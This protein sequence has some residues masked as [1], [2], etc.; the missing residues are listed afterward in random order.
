MAVRQVRLIFTTYSAF[1]PTHLALTSCYGNSA[2]LLRSVSQAASFSQFCHSISKDCSTFFTPGI[3][4]CRFSSGMHTKSVIP[5][6]LPVQKHRM[7]HL[8]TS[9][10]P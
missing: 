7:A 9:N 5:D 1:P 2:F 8:S 4:L 3:L 6:I 10:T